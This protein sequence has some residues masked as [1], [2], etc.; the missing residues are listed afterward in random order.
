VAGSIARSATVLVSTALMARARP[1]FYPNK[2][3]ETRLHQQIRKDTRTGT[4]IA[5]SVHGHTPS[6]AMAVKK[7]PPEFHK[8]NVLSPHIPPSLFPHKS[9]GDDTFL[10]ASFSLHGQV[11]P[12]SS[13]QN[14]YPRGTAATD[15]CG[16]RKFITSPKNDALTVVFDILGSLQ[17]WGPSPR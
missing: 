17:L 9:I 7:R 6:Y 2:Q 13:A 12:C 16:A 3:N 5:I 14:C 8:F 15:F 1:Q 10:T 4:S 11:P